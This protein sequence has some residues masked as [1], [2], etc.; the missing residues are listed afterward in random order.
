MIAQWW[1]HPVQRVLT[2]LLF[3]PMIRLMSLSLPLI[4]F[5]MPIWWLTVSVPLFL[6]VVVAVRVLNVSWKQTGHSLGYGQWYLALPLQLLIGGL[7]IVFG[8]TEY[9]I[10]RPTPLVEPLTWAT[11]WFPALVLLI[12]TGYLEELLFRGVMQEVVKE[13]VGFW[14]SNLFVSL[15]FA[16]LHVGYASLSD[17]IFVFVASLILG[18]CFEKTGSLLGVTLAHG[19]TNI[20]LFIVLPVIMNLPP[21][22]NLPF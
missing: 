12:S 14:A 4:G 8:L 16:A 22:F 6:S 7:G 18:Y 17:Y 3:A 13:T 1:E 9:W 21:I 19:L 2:V 5:E 10:L 11:M 15:I 20:L